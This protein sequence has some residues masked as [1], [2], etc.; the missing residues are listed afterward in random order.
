MLENLL[1]F[2]VGALVGGCFTYHMLC[3]LIV[4]GVKHNTK[5]A[6][7]LAQILLEKIEESKEN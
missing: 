7:Q 3:E 4:W 6:K 5:E 1:I 2:A